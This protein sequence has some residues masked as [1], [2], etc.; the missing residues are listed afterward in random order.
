MRLGWRGW[1]AIVL[2]APPLL[3]FLVVIGAA[4][5]VGATSC[6]HIDGVSARNGRGDLVAEETR[7]CGFVGF[8][9]ETQIRLR[10]AHALGSTVLV[11]Y[12]PL[13]DDLRIRW[14]GDDSVTIDLGKVTWIGQPV[15]KVRSIRIQ[16]R[17][18]E[19][20]IPPVSSTPA[21]AGP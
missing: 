2:L 3:V 17:Y 11:E 15:E 8:F 10:R 13:G 4:A 9:N 7:A 21:K 6:D 14:D 19:I 20:K 18:E 16:Y 5:W 1:L 12:D